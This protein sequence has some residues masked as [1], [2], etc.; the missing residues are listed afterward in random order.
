MKWILFLL[1][2]ILL[3][4]SVIPTLSK[5]REQNAPCSQIKATVVEN[6]IKSVPKKGGGDQP[7]LD[8][9]ATASRID[10][11]ACPIDNALLARAVKAGLGPDISQRVQCVGSGGSILCC[12]GASGVFV[13]CSR[14]GCMAN[15]RD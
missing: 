6:L 2:T 12:A 11:G 10:P 3:L 14:G 13:C 9:G 15:I 7:K 4:T 5:P 1:G 8:A